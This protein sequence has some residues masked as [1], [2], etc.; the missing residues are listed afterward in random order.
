MVKDQE[1]GP[2]FAP[3][4]RVAVP[5]GLDVVRGTVVSTSGHGP[6]RRVVVSVELPGAEG[7]AETELVTLPATALEDAAK[8]ASEHLPGA[9]LPAYRYEEAL[10][11]ALEQLVLGDTGL[12]SLGRE[13]LPIHDSPWDFVLDV[14]GHRLVIEAKSLKSGPISRK[15]VDRLLAYLSNSRN[16][17]ALLVANTA[18]SADAVK[19]VQEALEQ[20]YGIRAIQWRS[21]DDNPMLGRAIREL[22]SPA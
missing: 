8:V 21:S 3:G 15:I 22:L 7:S 18:L 17:A 1:C 16:T 2:P 12:G 20:G 19:R 13:R 5:W 4:D 10:R 14:G 9:W 11:D 6:G